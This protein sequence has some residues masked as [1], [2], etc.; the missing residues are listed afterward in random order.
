M[1]LFERSGH[2][3]MSVLHPKVGRRFSSMQL[4]EKDFNDLRKMSPEQLKEWVSY[5]ACGFDA[6][7]MPS[8]FVDPTHWAIVQRAGKTDDPHCGCSPYDQPHTNA[9]GNQNPLAPRGDSTP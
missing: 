8:Y 2:I 4:C 5:W 7:A 1:I 9:C 6:G 3:L